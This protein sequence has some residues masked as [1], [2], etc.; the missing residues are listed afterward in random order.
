MKSPPRRLALVLVAI[1]ATTVVNASPAR[2]GFPGENGLIA[3]ER[4]FF[5]TDS[6]IWVMN[7]DGSGQHALIENDQNDRFP[8][9]SADGTTIAFES[10]GVDLDIWAA[11][12]DGS[13]LRNLSND[14][15]GPDLSP[16]WSPDGTQLAFWKQNFD[17]TGSIWVMD[18]DGSNQVELT[19]ETS[20][21]SHPA[22][23][24]DGELIAYVSNRSG[25]NELYV[26]QPDGSGKRRLTFTS[27]SQEDHPNWSP[28]GTMLAFEACPGDSWPCVGSANTEVFV[29]NR[30]GTGR[31]RLTDDPTI[32]GNPAWSPDG[33]EVVFRSDRSEDGTNLW[34]MNADGTDPVQLTFPETVGPAGG[35]DP[36]WQPIV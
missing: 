15:S 10:S 26:M 31:A 34:K 3:W 7:P 12:A 22:W 32:D 6:D 30:D 35:V 13:N 20:V 11:D 1:A 17:G 9:W 24:P 2:A 25:G 16:A 21:Y 8:A 18:A 33:T 4:V 28:D 19:P 27:H 14:P 36:D 29:I 5:F 23:S